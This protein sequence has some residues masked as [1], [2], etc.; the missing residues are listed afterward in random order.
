[1]PAPLVWKRRGASTQ[2]DGNQPDPTYVIDVSSNLSKHWWRQHHRD[3]H[4]R[5]NHDNGWATEATLCRNSGKL[6][7]W[8]ISVPSGAGHRNNCPTP[9]G[10][11]FVFTSTP[12]SCKK[13]G[14]TPALAS[15]AWPRL[16]LAG[17]PRL[18]LA[19]LNTAPQAK[20]E[21]PWGKKPLKI[22]KKLWDILKRSWKTLQE[23]SFIKFQCTWRCSQR[24][25]LSAGTVL[26]CFAR[27]FN[28]FLMFY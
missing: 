18:A 9:G 25:F 26:E 22:L 6:I 14:P 21:D 12:P 16:A 1:M 20:K 28:I 8:G 5:S 23:G 3:A 10:F 2:P 27:T 15:L 4:N 13:W 24:F 11:A 17:R 7:P 19:G